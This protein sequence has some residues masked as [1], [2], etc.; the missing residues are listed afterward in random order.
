MNKV[1]EFSM[2]D[3]TLLF[4]GEAVRTNFPG[5]IL[6]G[7]YRLENGAYLVL[8]TEDCPYEEVLHILLLDSELRLLDRIDIG[9][10]YHG[11]IFEN[12]KIIDR[13]TLEFDFLGGLTFRLTLLSE[14]KRFV[15]NAF[16][17]SLIRHHWKFGKKHMRVEIRKD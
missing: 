15:K 8:A 6:E 3:S 13:E 7:Q 2:A 4:G 10:E 16:F 14:G 12:A 17:N 5:R 11:G 9:L 1:D